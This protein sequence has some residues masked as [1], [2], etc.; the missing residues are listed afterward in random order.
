MDVLSQ[1]NENVGSGDAVTETKRPRLDADDQLLTIRFVKLSPD[2]QAPVYGSAAAAGA[3]LFSAEDCVVPAHGN[4]M[5]VMLGISETLC[6][7]PIYEVGGIPLFSENYTHPLFKNSHY[8]SIITI[9]RAQTFSKMSHAIHSGATTEARNQWSKIVSSFSGKFC[10]STGLQVELPFGYYGRVAPR[11]GL[12]AKNFIDVGAG[13][14]DSDYRGELKVLLFNFGPSD[15]EVRG[16][17]SCLCSFVKKGDRIAQFICERIAHCKYEEC[18]TL[19]DTVRGEG[20]F[21]S[22]GK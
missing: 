21:G 19:T 4:T 6:N 16:R 9:S 1:R 22:T 3:D 13:V 17:L 11:S 15:F 7:R 14:V 20:G 8:D 5:P 10:V 12:A 18:T 2:A